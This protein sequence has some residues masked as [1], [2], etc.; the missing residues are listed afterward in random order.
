MLIQQENC[1]LSIL[2]NRGNLSPGSSFQIRGKKKKGKGGEEGKRSWQTW[3]NS[4]PF[5]EEQIVKFPN[6]LF[7]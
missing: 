4:L 1:N 6:S 2:L 3:V 7:K 5:R